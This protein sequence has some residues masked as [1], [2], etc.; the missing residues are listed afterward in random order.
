MGGLRIQHC[1]RLQHRLNMAAWIQRCYGVGPSC[2]F[3]LTPS[4]GISIGHRCSLKKTK[5]ERERYPC[6]KK[7]KCNDYDVYRTLTAYKLFHML[8][9]FDLHNDPIRS[10]KHCSHLANEE[11]VD[12]TGWTTNLSRTSEGAR[13]LSSLSKQDSFSHDLR[14]PS[15]LEQPALSGSVLETNLCKSI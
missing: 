3:D 7:K 8:I 15:C 5:K 9:T 1:C 12:L 10:A 4:P 11:T 13:I 14:R 6:L 2:S